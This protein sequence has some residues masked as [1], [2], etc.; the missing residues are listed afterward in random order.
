M[1]VL[2]YIEEDDLYRYDGVRKVLTLNSQ[3]DVAT[4]I[5]TFEDAVKKVGYKNISYVVED[6]DGYY[7]FV[8]SD[9]EGIFD[10]FKFINESYVE[11]ILVTCV[12]ARMLFPSSKSRGI[13]VFEDEEG[14]TS[15]QDVDT[16]FL[17]ESDL[18]DACNKTLYLVHKKVGVNIDI[19]EQ[20]L[21]IGRSSKKVDYLVQDNTNVGREHCKLYLD[22]K[23][24]MVHDYNSKNG[25]FVNN[26]RVHSDKDVQ[27]V[28]GDTLSLANE[29]FI[30]MQ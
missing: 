13:Y 26:R 4:L 25:T 24:L 29:E 21:V 23:K 20:G 1:N 22:G 30:V 28:V 14:V 12:N 10:L 5:E 18:P 7:F 27:L 15:E 2:S 3:E 19:P 16:D 9:R 17:D 8:I 6:E 11:D